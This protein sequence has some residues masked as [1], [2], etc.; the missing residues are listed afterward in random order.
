MSK[1][2]MIGLGRIGWQVL[3][4]LVQD[5]KCPELVCCDMSPEGQSLVDNAVIG[6]SI[7][8]L[9]P[10]VKFYQL[11]V[12]DMEATTRIITAE[13]PDVVIDMSVMMPMHGFYK[14]PKK[15][16]DYLYSATFGAWLPCQVALPYR[17][18]QAVKQSGVDAKVITSGLPDLVIPALASVGMAPTI[19]MGNI[20]LNAAAL[21]ILVSRKMNVPAECVKVYLVSEHAWVV[22]PRDSAYSK[23]PYYLRIMVNDKDVT[24]HFDKDQLMWDAIKLYPPAP[25]TVFYTGSSKSI[26]NNMYAL[27]SPVGRFTHAPGPK[28]L[29]GGYPVIISSKGVE[30]ALPEGITEEEAVRINCEAQRIGEGIESINPDGTCVWTDYAHDVLKDTIGFDLR[31]FN[32][33]DSY[34]VALDMKEKYNRYVAKFV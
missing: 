24:N 6:A 20:N 23:T 30:L 22:Y 27:L 33:R 26:I 34:E 29:P 10:S 1:V 18:M 9:Y 7:T 14:L 11:D 17:L 19:G 16:F 21:T 12:S 31:S 32:V 4:Y 3:E 2:M 5:I 8:G 15:Q 13:K 28:G 25:S